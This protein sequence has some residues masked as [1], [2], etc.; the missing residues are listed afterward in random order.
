MKLSLFLLDHCFFSSTIGLLI[1]KH[2]GF[3]VW[4]K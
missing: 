1:T 2:S 4:F 3:Y